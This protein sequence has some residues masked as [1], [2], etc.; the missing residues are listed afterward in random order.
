MKRS[1]RNKRVAVLCPGPSIKQTWPAGKT[2]NRY[3]ILIGVNRAVLF[4]RVHVWAFNDPRVFIDHRPGYRPQLL[5]ARS[6][7]YKI[8][9]A[10]LHDELYRHNIQHTDRIEYP[11]R[12]ATG[13]T[14]YTYPTALAYCK[15]LGARRVDVYG[16]DQTDE[17]DFDGKMDVGCHRNAARWENERVIVGQT[18]KWLDL[19]GI[20]IERVTPEG[21]YGL[22]G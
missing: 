16:N 17:P 11:L 3:D 6:A 18:V 12:I 7:E 13:F 22:T 1:V 8:D 19:C 9:K 21:R 5:M 15:T 4:D 2:D 10:G 20:R 14:N